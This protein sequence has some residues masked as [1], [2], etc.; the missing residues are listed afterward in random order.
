LEAGYPGFDSAFADSSYNTAPL[1]NVLK[2]VERA[3]VWVTSKIPE[4]HWYDPKDTY[5]ILEMALK[6]IGVDYVDLMLLHGPAAWGNMSVEESLQR[7][8]AGMEAFY[9]AG[10]ARAIG[11]SNYCPRALRSILRKA[12]IVPHVNQV[13]Y[14]A[15]MGE[16]PDG[17]LSFCRFHNITVQ[18]ESA[19]DW[20]N[21]AIVHGADYMTVGERHNKSALQVALRWLAQ[22]GYPLI[23]ESLNPQHQREDINIFD[24]NLTAAEIALISAQENCRAGEQV[25][26]FCHVPYYQTPFR[27]CNTDGRHSQCANW[28]DEE[29]LIGHSDARTASP[30][31]VV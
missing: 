19:S 10:K 29:I 31:I 3:S 7:Q 23:V 13:I 2:T 18:A 1:K 4:G 5:K 30:E 15:G 9:R 27:C 21:P 26:P 20:V 28:G 14:H 12:T 8:W 24:F 17:L 16:D 25:P 22:R 11:V 6:D